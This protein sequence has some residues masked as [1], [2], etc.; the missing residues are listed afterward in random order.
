MNNRLRWADLTE[1][2]KATICNGCGPKG[3]FI[4]I[5]NFL[6]R[7][8]CDHHD[9]KYWRGGDWFDRLVADQK[10]L[11]AMLMDAR[12]QPFQAGRRPLHERLWFGLWAWTYY[13]AVR[14]FGSSAFHHGKERTRGD[15]FWARAKR[16]DEQERQR[17]SLGES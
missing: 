1:E 17:R 15:L 12:F 11:D 14:V 4:K 16:R 13:T 6:F 3:G 9:F 7:A 5:P 2:D 8:S 10:F